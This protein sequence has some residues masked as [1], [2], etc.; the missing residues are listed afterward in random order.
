MSDP[1]FGAASR[2]FDPVEPV[3]LVDFLAVGFL[4]VLSF[5]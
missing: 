4:V 2:Y 3:P 1:V 5:F